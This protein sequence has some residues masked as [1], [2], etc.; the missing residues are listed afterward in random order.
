MK[1]T[2]WF[3]E[4]VHALVD[5]GIV[6]GITYN[7]FAPQDNVTRA[8]FVQMLA[9]ASGA[10]LSTYTCEFG[11]VATSDW[12]YPAVA[13]ASSVGVVGG[14]S[15]T[16]FAPNALISRQ[17]MAL[18][19]SRYISK[20]ANTTLK[21]SP[22]PIPFNDDADIADYA[23]DAVMTMK[24]AGVIGGKLNNR[25]APRENATRAE[26]AKIIHTMLTKTGK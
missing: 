15:E 26:A 21:E 7:K 17:D 11:D 18:M 22:Y 14:I 2:D 19:L 9:R 4:A 8:Q 16:H 5:R 3:Y 13:W 25:F 10:D 6:N 1:R 24:N 23:R 12:F 20:V